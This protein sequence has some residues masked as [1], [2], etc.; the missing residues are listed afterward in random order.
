MLFN[1]SGGS[2]PQFSALKGD[3][4]KRFGNE[5]IKISGEAKE[6]ANKFEVTR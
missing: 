1:R 2:E 5:A 6:E 3:M 4:E